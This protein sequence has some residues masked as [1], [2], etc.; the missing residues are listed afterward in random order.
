MVPFSGLYAAKS[1]GAVQAVHLFAIH[2]DF[3]SFPYQAVQRGFSVKHPKKRWSL[4]LSAG[5]IALYPLSNRIIS[6]ANPS[7]IAR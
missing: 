6:I 7:A 2:D 1:P 5:H 3:L 4:T